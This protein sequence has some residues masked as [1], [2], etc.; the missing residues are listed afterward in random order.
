MFGKLFGWANGPSR[1]VVLGGDGGAL[2]R[3]SPGSQGFFYAPE[4]IRTTT[5]F[6]HDNAL[7]LNQLV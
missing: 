3:K 2:T 5:M 6:T 1:T 4:W 7:N